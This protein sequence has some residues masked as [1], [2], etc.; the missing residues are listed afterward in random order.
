MKYQDA[1]NLCPNE[2]LKLAL[3]GI[4][5]AAEDGKIGG[6]TIIELEKSENLSNVRTLVSAVLHAQQVIQE[7]G[8]EILRDKAG[9]SAGTTISQGTTLI[10]QVCIL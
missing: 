4:L 9:M 7:H 1:L 8:H 10:P 2:I 3:G 5:F 6:N